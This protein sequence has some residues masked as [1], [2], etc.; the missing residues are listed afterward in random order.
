MEKLSAAVR[1][2]LGAGGGVDGGRAVG[3]DEAEDA[4]DVLETR[5]LTLEPPDCDLEAT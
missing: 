4:G 1:L 3:A 2:G 5:A